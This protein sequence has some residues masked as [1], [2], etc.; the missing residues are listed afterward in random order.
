MSDLETSVPVDAQEPSSA[1]SNQPESTL[2]DHFKKVLKE[3]KNAMERVRE[4]ETR[5]KQTEEKEMIRKE[6]FKSLAETKE[7]EAN[8]WKTKF[9]STNKLIRD[10]LKVNKVRDE[11]GKLGMQPQYMN[12]ALRMID[13]NTI[14]VDEDTKVVTGHDSAAKMLQETFPPLFSSRP[15]NVSGAAPAT[16]APQTLTL[17]EWKKL[18]NDQKRAR[19]KDLYETMGIKRVK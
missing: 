10:G 1:D 17:E 15:T 7:R 5:L 11:L 6:E 2:P 14:D 19:E 18:P 4:L 12:H 13:L 3:K 9:E 8:E 16:G